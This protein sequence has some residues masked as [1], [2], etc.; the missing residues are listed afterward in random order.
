[1]NKVVK[2][3]NLRSIFK[4][5]MTIMIGGFLDCGTPD[6]LIDMLID[7]NVKNLTI[8]SNDTSFPDKGIGRLIV[9]SQVKKV[10]ASHI[11]TNPETGRKIITGEMNVELSPQG[12]LIERIRAGGSGLGGV[13]TQ[14]GLGTVVEDGKQKLT[15]SGK[16]YLLELPL[17]ADVALVKGSVVDEFGNTCYKGTTKNF[18]PYIAM[19]AEKVIVEA[20]KLVKCNQLETEYVMTPGVLVDYIVKGVA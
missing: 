6:G 18:N 20:E 13:L 1:M 2:F 4:D 16:E 3:E 14:T 15:I 8:I 7:L 17:K 19:A 9:N 10:I 11:G 5:G 12:T